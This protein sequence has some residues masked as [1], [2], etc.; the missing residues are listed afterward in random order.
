MSNRTVF[1]D[2]SA[3]QQHIDDVDFSWLVKLRILSTRNVSAE[4]AT[5]LQRASVADW[6][7][8]LSV[9]ND[10]CR[11]TPGICEYHF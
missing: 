4:V 10:A 3:Q 6:V 11:G 5:S 2:T 1:K 8:P 9:Y 7:H